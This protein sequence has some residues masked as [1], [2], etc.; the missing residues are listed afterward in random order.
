MLWC[1]DLPK[2]PSHTAAADRVRLRKRTRAAAASVPSTDPDCRVVIRQEGWQENPTRPLQS[3]VPIRWGAE[4]AAAPEPHAPAWSDWEHRL[5]SKTRVQEWMKRVT[6]LGGR[7]NI[8]RSRK[9]N[10][11]SGHGAASWYGRYSPGGGR[12]STTTIGYGAAAASEPT[13]PAGSAGCTEKEGGGLR[14]EVPHMEKS[15]DR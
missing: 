7:K 15:S 9:N 4:S 5:G 8:C 13:A 1:S 6:L 12:S 3:F 2:E 10:R 11:A 14:G